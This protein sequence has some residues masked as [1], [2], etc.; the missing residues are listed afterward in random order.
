MQVML[1]LQLYKPAYAG[2]RVLLWL[3]DV[4]LREN[5]DTMYVER[6]CF[7]VQWSAEG[8]K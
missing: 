1:Y 8:D 7:N 6:D 2:A 4:G 3:T 5:S